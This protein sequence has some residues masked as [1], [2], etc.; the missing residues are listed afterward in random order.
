M[1]VIPDGHAVSPKHRAAGSTWAVFGAIWGVLLALSGLVALRDRALA[2]P[3]LWIGLGGALV[4]AI[5]LSRVSLQWCGDQLEYRSLLGTRTIRFSEIDSAGIA[6]GRGPFEPPM[7]LEIRPKQ[8]RASFLRINLKLF[9]VVA[10]TELRDV[11]VA[12][13]VEIR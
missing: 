13:G 1:Q 12:H 2:L 7:L 9:S 5:V 4:S 11:L 3:F 10:V 6:G 8:K